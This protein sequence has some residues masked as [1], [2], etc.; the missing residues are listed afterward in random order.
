MTER[1]LSAL[2]S[3]VI[4]TKPHRVDVYA[5]RMFFSNSLIRICQVTVIEP[6]LPR[7]LPPVI[8]NLVIEILGKKLI[9]D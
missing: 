7:R 5:C 6:V 4:V 2:I 3:M 8:V 1:K 9:S